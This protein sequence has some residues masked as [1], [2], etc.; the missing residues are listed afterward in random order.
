MAFLPVHAVSGV[1]RFSVLRLG[2]PPKLLSGS[3]QITGNGR[4]EFSG[5]IPPISPWPTNQTLRPIKCVHIPQMAE[6][7]TQIS[8][9]RRRFAEKRS[10]PWHG[11]MGLIQKLR[12]AHNS[13]RLRVSPIHSGVL[14]DREREAS[15][16]AG[17]N[18]PAALWIGLLR[19]QVR[20]RP[21]QERHADTCP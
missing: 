13:A 12:I 18:D 21:R 15:Q 8:L 9:M 6:R 4:I 10:G 1:C 16:L 7:T 2:R 11:V 3:G 20:D 5:Q 19:V 17:S 14:T